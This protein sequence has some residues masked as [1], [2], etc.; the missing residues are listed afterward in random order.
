MTPQAL[1]GKE[2]LMTSTN[3]LAH[4]RYTT[5]TFSTLLVLGLAG[6]SA[7]A[8]LGAGA[9]GLT[10][11]S[12]QTVQPLPGV[13][14][15]SSTPSSLAKE[16]LAKAITEFEAHHPRRAMAALEDLRHQVKQAHRDAVSLIGAPPT[17]PES[18]E[19]PGPPAVLDMLALEHR[20]TT[21]L[22][23]EFDGRTGA[24]VVD[25]L[26][27]TVRST[28]NRRDAMLDQV[29]ALKPGARGD[30]EDGM[31]DTLNQYPKEEQQLTIALDTYQLTST[32]QTALHEA[33]VQ[34]RATE[35]K[36]TPVFG[37]GE[38]TGPS[39]GR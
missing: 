3:W 38:R 36:V 33:L 10:T 39:Q 37:G 5:T 35:A 4:S 34:V 16:A 19:P 32:G 31:A 12:T 11:A 18:D 15:T 6:L 27:R 24:D 9:D 25:A 13:V 22:V 23:P 17:D 29:I 28:L 7:P 2:N 1:H 21:G 26:H 8:A 14:R 20:V 30:Y